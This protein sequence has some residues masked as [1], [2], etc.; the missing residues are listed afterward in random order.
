[1]LLCNSR[2]RHH[3]AVALHAVLSRVSC[4]RIAG[5]H[6]E[7]STLGIVLSIHGIECNI[8]MFCLK[9]P[10]GGSRG[11]QRIFLSVFV[12]CCPSYSELTHKINVTI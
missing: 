3:A 6:C 5:Q 12:V 7:K 10:T 8:E 11:E 1:M 2:W 9:S 4:W